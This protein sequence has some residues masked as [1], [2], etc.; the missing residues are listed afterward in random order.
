[1]REIQ[2]ESL[3]ELAL[4]NTIIDFPI[5]NCHLM[6]L[7]EWMNLIHLRPFVV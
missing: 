4:I 5:N 2:V 3:H 6:I 1:M 7:N